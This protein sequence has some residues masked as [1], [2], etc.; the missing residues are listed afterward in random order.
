MDDLQ[1]EKEQIEEIRAW[2][3]EY[4]RYVIG[5]IVLG[6][7]LLFGWN[8]YQ[9]SHLEAQTSASELFEQLA[10]EVNRGDLDAAE[11]TADELAN[12]YSN[13]PYAAQSKLAMAKL[14]MDK[15]RDQ[16]AADVLTELLALPS[17][18]SLQHVGRVR[19]AKILLYQDKADAVVELLEAQQSSAFKGRYSEL[20]GD[21]Y[22]QLGEFEQAGDAYRRALEDPSQ[23]IDRGLVQMKLLDLP[24]ASA[25][26]V[27]EQADEAEA[28]P[29]V[30]DSE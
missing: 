21:A 24:E 14:Y 15:N 10:D 4:G 30:E 17:G 7:A 9:S 6:A 19:L 13:T 2:W 5:G 28:L 18:D 8:Y 23:T 20:L 12:N 25:E 29:E 22:T 1:S 3:A 27:E 11:S 26:Q 16:D